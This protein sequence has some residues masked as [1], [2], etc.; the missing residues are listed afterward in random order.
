MLLHVVSSAM[1]RNSDFKPF[2]KDYTRARAVYRPSPGST[3]IEGHAI[4]LVGCGARLLG[5]SC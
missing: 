3:T 2:F 4:T 5:G 1:A